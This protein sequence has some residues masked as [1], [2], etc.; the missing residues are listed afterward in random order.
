MIDVL[1]D[2]K[3]IWELKDLRQ[4]LQLPGE[5]Y[6]WTVTVPF[7]ILKQNVLIMVERYG[8]LRYSICRNRILRF[9]LA[10]K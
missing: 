2:K 1:D 3:V 7:I 5:Q 4:G 10:F 9:I 8:K 6:A